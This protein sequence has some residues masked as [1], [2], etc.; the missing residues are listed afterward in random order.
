VAFSE[1]S[2]IYPSF[3]PPLA[4]SVGR[5]QFPIT[6]EEGVGSGM[7]ALGMGLSFSTGGLSDHSNTNLSSLSDGKLSVRSQG[8]SLCHPMVHRA[9]RLCPISLP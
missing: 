4:T 3:V 9:L 6:P 8:R 7:G 2:E 5:D 1:L